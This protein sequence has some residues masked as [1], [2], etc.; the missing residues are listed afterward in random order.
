[1]ALPAKA[2]ERFAK[3]VRFA[4]VDLVLKAT[5]DATTASAV[6]ILVG[7]K[8][9]VTVHVAC[10]AVHAYS[11]ADTIDL[12]INVVVAD[13]DAVLV[14]GIEIV[15]LIQFH[16]WFD[17]MQKVADYKFQTTMIVAEPR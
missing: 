8:L 3:V 5:D 14:V 6:E 15:F 2:V 16:T 4:A 17:I 12:D 10:I 13:D 7:N 1:M 11:V 9:M